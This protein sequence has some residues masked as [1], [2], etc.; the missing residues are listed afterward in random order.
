M[1][2][3]PKWLEHFK[4]SPLSLK[5]WQTEA[6]PGV[7][8]T[9]SLLIL[10]HLDEDSYIEWAAQF[11]EIPFIQPEFLVS[12]EVRVCYARSVGPPPSE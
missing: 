6:D 7:S 3:H 11:Y 1:G 4:I 5:E 12:T 8:L 9:H 10:G 2:Y